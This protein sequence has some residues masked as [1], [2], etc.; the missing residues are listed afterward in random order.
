MEAERG[1]WRLII[2]VENKIVSH[3]QS[4]QEKN[5]SKC[6]WPQ[7]K[8]E[9]KGTISTTQ[10]QSRIQVMAVRTSVATRKGEKKGKTICFPSRKMS[11]MNLNGLTAACLLG[12]KG[13]SMVL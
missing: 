2:K 7:G 11:S 6:K 13:L 10:V 5:F 8:E 3:F 9:I 4:L 1:P 12:V